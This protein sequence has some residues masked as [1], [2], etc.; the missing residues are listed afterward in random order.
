MTPPGVVVASV[1]RTFVA[2]AAGVGSKVGVAAGSVEISSVAS[3]YGHPGG[4]SQQE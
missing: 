1:T 3:K 4:F 2:Y